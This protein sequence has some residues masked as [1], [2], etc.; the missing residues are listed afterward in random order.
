MDDAPVIEPA[1]KPRSRVTLVGY[2]CTG[3]STV[4]AILA[5][6]LG[7]AW[8][9]ADTLL[10]QRFGTS[11]SDLVRTRGEA[12]FRDAEAAI[13]A[14]LLERDGV[15]IA[16]GGGVVL[17]EGNRRLLHT[18][19]RPVVWLTAAPAELRRRLASDPASRDRRPGL[20]GPDP[21]AEVEQALAERDPLY[22]GIA[23]VAFDSGA[24]RPDEVAD[25]IAAW[26]A[27]PA[28]RACRG[29]SP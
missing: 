12:A 8:C 3:K 14:E 25:R 18:R 24:I 16:T 7:A 28:G 2:R 20:S 6:R 5:A 17:R 29:P 4:A 27:T 26:L 19:G 11:I 21:L 15:V 10:E 9:D 13:L 23:D 22:R 1:T